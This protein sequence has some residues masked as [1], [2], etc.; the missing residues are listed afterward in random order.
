MI[1]SKPLLTCILFILFF[2]ISYRY[3]PRELGAYVAMQILYRHLDPFAQQYHND[4]LYNR[5]LANY[6]L[7]HVNKPPATSQTSLQDMK[8]R[9]LKF[10][11]PRSIVCELPADVMYFSSN[12]PTSPNETVTYVSDN[13]VSASASFGPLPPR[14]VTS[15]R[16]RYSFSF[17][18]LE[19]SNQFLLWIV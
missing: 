12:L 6:Q 17:P 13:S 11:L 8:N 15:V 10:V 4:L 9:V 14:R 1:D 5:K 2:L 19:L 7:Q 16:V 18:S 3:N